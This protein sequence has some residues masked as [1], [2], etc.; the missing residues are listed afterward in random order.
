MYLNIYFFIKFNFFWFYMNFRGFYNKVFY[1]FYFLVFWQ[2]IRGF[3]I[4]FYFVILYYFFCVW[5]INFVFLFKITL[6]ICDQL[7]SQRNDKHEN[8]G[9]EW[10]S[11][12]CYRKVLSKVTEASRTLDITENVLKRW[13]NLILFVHNIENYQSMCPEIY[14]I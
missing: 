4:N 7:K 5:I 2:F 14:L 10:F 6:E 12:A 1:S 8:L 9:Y 11:L 3:N 13:Q